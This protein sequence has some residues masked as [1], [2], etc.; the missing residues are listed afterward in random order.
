MIE[1]KTK[2]Y[3]KIKIVLAEKYKKVFRNKNIYFLEI[4]NSIYV[5]NKLKI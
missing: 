3:L 2:Y 1:V 4:I 5:L